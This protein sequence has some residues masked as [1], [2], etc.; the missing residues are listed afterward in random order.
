MINVC[1]LCVPPKYI[2]ITINGCVGWLTLPE[3]LRTHARPLNAFPLISSFWRG[4][5][6]AGSHAYIADYCCY[7]PTL[8]SFKSASQ[9]PFWTAMFFWPSI[10][11]NKP[12]KHVGEQKWQHL[13]PNSRS[14]LSALETFASACKCQRGVGDDCSQFCRMKRDSLIDSHSPWF[15]M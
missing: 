12:Q 10:E 8:D 5:I 11:V 13:I 6:A 2:I 15:S 1:V 4:G 9:F 7:I 3:D 14:N